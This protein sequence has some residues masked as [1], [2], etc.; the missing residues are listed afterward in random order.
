M[1]VQVTRAG[2]RN[3]AEIEQAIHA[4]AQ[5][6]NGGLVISPSSMT[7]RHRDLII[8]LAAKSRLPAVYPYRIF[9]QSGGLISYGA[10]LRDAT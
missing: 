6:P 1:G 9:A 5:H 3:A 2:V 10:D 7:L 4:F 8:D